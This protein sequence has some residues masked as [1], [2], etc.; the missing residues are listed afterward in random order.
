MAFPSR[1]ALHGMECEGAHL[2][3]MSWQA[4]LRGLRPVIQHD[5]CRWTESSGRE[6]RS[7]AHHL[8]MIH[9]AAKT[10]T[11]R[12]PTELYMNGP[13]KNSLNSDIMALSSD[14]LLVTR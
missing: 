2:P 7:T 3:S 9:I 11:A 8:R 5:I 14:R 6:S 12:T 10:Q 1:R 13:V 4:H